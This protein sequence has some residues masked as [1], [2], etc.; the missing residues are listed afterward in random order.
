MT[1]LSMHVQYTVS[2]LFM[3]Q[4]QYML[5]ILDRVGMSDCKPCTI[6]VNVNPKHP[7]V[8]DP[9]ADPT[10]FHISVGA[11]QYLTFTRPE[12]SYAVQQ[13]CLHMH[14]PR[15]PHLAALKRI[16]RYICGTLHLGLLI[17]PSP[18]ELVV[19]SDANWVD[20]LDTRR[21]TSGYAIFSW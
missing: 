4:C 9:V 3:N 16:L 21:S 6:P 2:S 18:S 14:D 17:R 20:C 12:I 13:A 10:V 7:V 11:L 1:P 15:E 8:G 19:N 5:E